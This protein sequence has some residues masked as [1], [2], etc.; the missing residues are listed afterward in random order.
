[1]EYIYIFVNGDKEVIY[2]GRTK[3]IKNRIRQHFGKEGHLEKEAYLMTTSIYYSCVHSANEA[4]IYEL[5]YISKHHPKY[6]LVFGDG[7]EISFEL[8]ELSFSIF[9]LNQEMKFSNLFEENE[10]L[11]SKIELLEKEKRILENKIEEISHYSKRIK[12]DFLELVEVNEKL[13]KYNSELKNLVEINGLEE[14]SFS[15][16][17]LS[18]TEKVSYRRVIMKY[19]YVDDSGK[20]HYFK[21]ALELESF[22]GDS[23]QKI[24]L[25]VKNNKLD[26]ELKKINR[27][28]TLDV[29]GNIIEFHDNAVPKY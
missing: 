25:N 8:P 13:H 1:M 28:L 18:F 14:D 24:W 12:S 22:F 6:N 11:M 19:L 3:N 4:R 20:E 5:Y 17:I 23:A 29:N 26:G 2:V 7:G 15:N 9:T 27:T 21:N 16:F 10:Y